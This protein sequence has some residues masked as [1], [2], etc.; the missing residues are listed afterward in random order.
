MRRFYSAL[1]YCLSPYLLAR[2]WWKGRKLPAYRQRIAE[3]FGYSNKT[4]QTYDVWVHAVSLGEVIAAI[5]LIEGLLQKK[6][7]LL[8]TTMTPTGAEKIQTHFKQRV[9]HRYI[10]YDLPFALKRFFNFNR[11]RLGIIMET[12]LWPNLITIASQQAIPLLLLNARLSKRSYQG[13]KKVKF[14]FKPI[15]NKF[16]CI[17]AQSQDDANHFKQLGA[18]VDKVMVGGNIKFD[19]Q[20]PPPKPHVLEFDNY[21][22][23][24]RVRVIVASTH[25]DEE[26]QILARLN[27]LKARIPN[28]LLLI[29]PRHPERFQ[30]VYQLSRKM[31]FKTTLRSQI[32]SEVNNED[33]IILDSIGELL[34]FYQISHYAFIGGSFVPVGGHNVL[35]PIAMQV[36]VFSGK[37]VHNFK[38]ICNALNNANAMILVDNADDLVAR[39]VELYNDQ[40]KRQTL[41]NNATRILNE[42]KGTVN[43]YLNKID[44]MLN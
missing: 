20:I 23:K 38:A 44:A 16:Q 40:G 2:L 22:G 8:I 41:I 10:P 15:L 39:L 3:R 19:L 35:E 9:T 30:K 6:K 24:N 29:A 28:L 14:L 13:Y 34:T 27:T 17:L 11:P 7:Q 36:P 4:K 26:Q 1:L 21:L 43:L 42:N 18:K 37:H 12:E 32:N 31:G 25:E 5:P 33:V